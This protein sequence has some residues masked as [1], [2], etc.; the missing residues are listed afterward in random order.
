MFDKQ[1][2]LR[3]KPLG[4]S[5]DANDRKLLAIYAIT[6]SIDVVSLSIIQIHSHYDKKSSLGRVA[7]ER[8][9]ERTQ[10]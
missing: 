7:G 1:I 4:K 10:T 8:G 3:S 6:D 5:V 9:T 2:K